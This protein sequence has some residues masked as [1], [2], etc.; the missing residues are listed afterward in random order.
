MENAHRDEFRAGQ[1]RR[2]LRCGVTGASNCTSVYFFFAYFSGSFLNFSK[3]A[4]EQK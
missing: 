1:R 2:L 3:S 4:R